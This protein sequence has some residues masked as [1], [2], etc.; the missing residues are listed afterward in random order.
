VALISQPI[1][2]QALKKLG[3]ALFAAAALVGPDTTWSKGPPAK[4]LQTVA[5]N[6]L[7]PQAQATER[8]ILAGGPFPYAKDGVVFG[9]RERILPPRPRGDYHEYTVPPPRGSSNRGAR[10]I[11][12]AGKQP[13]APEAC[14][15]T[16]DHY[17]S[18]RRI[19]K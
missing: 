10:R 14:Y 7:P 13:T 15:Y 19:V 4:E 9:N 3:L 6:D 12:C 18:F 1:R 17:A 8:L 2:R 5:F 11:V 16:D